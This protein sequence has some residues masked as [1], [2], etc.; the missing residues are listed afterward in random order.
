LARSA[1]RIFSDIYQNEFM[2]LDKGE[3]NTLQKAINEWEQGGILTPEK[4]EELRRNAVIKQSDR[5]QIAQ[6]FFF[7]AL[8]CTLLA[9]GAIFINEKLLEK[10]KV[11][12]SLNDLVIALISAALAVLWFWYVGRRRSHISLV[13]YETYMVLGGLSVLTSLIY[14]CKV[15]EINKTST[16]FL[17]MSLPV[18]TLLALFM[19]SRAIWIGALVC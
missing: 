6:Y 4:A 7:I 13:A 2:D 15:L 5:Q 18:L 16:A 17:S 3:W 1:F 14:C 11:Y 8:F 19:R 10:I 12:F 9:F